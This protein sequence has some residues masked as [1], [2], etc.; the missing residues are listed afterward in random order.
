M[1]RHSE[2]CAEIS[3]EEKQTKFHP[4]AGPEGG[5]YCTLHRY[6]PGVD[7][8]DFICCKAWINL[9]SPIFR[10][11]RSGPHS[12]S[13]MPGCFASH[14]GPVGSVMSSDGICEG[15]LVLVHS[16]SDLNWS[17]SQFDMQTYLVALLKN[18]Q[19][20]NKNTRPDS[21]PYSL[22]ITGSTGTEIYFNGTAQKANIKDSKI[23]RIQQSLD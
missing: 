17:L 14:T 4:V 2:Q 18:R 5:N 19:Q 8:M 22:Y 15:V 9:S 20:I 3:W 16:D 13:G 7:F 11:I 6:L 21:F 1:A 23:T 10:N 12:G